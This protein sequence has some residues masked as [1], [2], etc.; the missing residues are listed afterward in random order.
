MTW[1]RRLVFRTAFSSKVCLNISQ[2]NKVR[3]ERTHYEFKISSKRISSCPSVS[4]RRKG[5]VRKA[6]GCFGG[7][8]RPK[9]QRRN[10]GIAPPGARANSMQIS[11]PGQPARRKADQFRAQSY[12]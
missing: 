3:K 9:T 11:S 8:A 2:N 1:N 10:T 12:L 5:K 4:T 6:E 7:S